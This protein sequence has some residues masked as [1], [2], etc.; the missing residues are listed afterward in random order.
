MGDHYWQ[1]NP[2][3]VNL[4]SWLGM[5]RDRGVLRLWRSPLATLCVSRSCSGR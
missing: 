4:P 1:T 2:D 5:W 3:G